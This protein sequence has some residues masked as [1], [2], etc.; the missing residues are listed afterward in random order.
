[1]SP[2]RLD[3]GPWFIALTV[4]ALVAGCGRAPESPSVAAGAAPAVAVVDAVVEAGCGRC[5]FDLE[6]KDCTLA[7]RYEGTARFVTGT[8]IDQHGD[9]HADDGFCNAIRR[10]HVTGRIEGENFAVSTFELLPSKDG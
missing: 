2:V 10:A 3:L 8:S 9:A 7:V 4:A 6:G 5:L 1:M